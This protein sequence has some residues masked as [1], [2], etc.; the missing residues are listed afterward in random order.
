MTAYEGKRV[1]G[2]PNPMTNDVCMW[3]NKKTNTAQIL[4]VLNECMYMFVN[5]S[6]YVHMYVSMYVL[7]RTCLLLHTYVSA[8]SQ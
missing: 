7:V 3:S 1:V 8:R 6:M 4:R 5:L 2:D